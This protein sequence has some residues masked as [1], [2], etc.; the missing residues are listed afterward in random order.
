MLVLG[1]AA[2]IPGIRSLI[3]RNT[4]N[5]AF[6][7]LDYTQDLKGICVTDTIYGIYDYFCETTSDSNTISRE[8][9][10]DA[11][12]YYMGMYVKGSKA[13]EQANTLMEASWDFLEGTTDGSELEAL[14]YEVTGTIRPMPSDSLEFYKEYL[15]WD[16]M[17]KETQD[18]FLPYYLVVG[19][20][21]GS[22]MDAMIIFLAIGIIFIFIALF[23]F[24]KW[25]TGGCQKQVKK[26]I[27][28]SGNPE[29]AASR[30]E[31]FISSTIPLHNVL[32]S[33]EFICTQEGSLTIFAEMPR[34]VWAYMNVTTHRTNLIITY[35]TYMIT[36]GFMD[37]STKS[38]TMKNEQT[39][40][41]V[42]S[43]IAARAPHAVMGYSDELNQ[44]F[45]HDMDSFLNVKYRQVM[46]DPANQDYNSG[47]S[48]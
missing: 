21:G 3:A 43:V 37:G 44:A 19:E 34:M 30:V 16:T 4:V 27:A 29:M 8:Y 39:G 47:F 12:D 48:I 35:K 9:I 45:R 26:Y 6:E 7:E 36:L 31:N 18:L 32:I 15:E 41:E 5:P 23:L 14:Q 17:D 33:N 11:G 2:L 13:L 1:I 22:N 20:A 28:S 25:S 42:L 10:I 38:F 40:R 24:F 46:A